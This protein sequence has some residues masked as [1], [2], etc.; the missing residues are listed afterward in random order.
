MKPQTVQNLADDLLE[1]APA[2]SE[3]IFGSSDKKALR[4][5]YHWLDL[6][7]IPSTK[8]GAKRISTKSAIRAR[9]APKSSG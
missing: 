5:T 9:L 7:V 3:F 8:A 2:M 1:G 6:G 4:K